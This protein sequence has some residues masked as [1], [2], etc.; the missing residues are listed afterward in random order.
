MKV[1]YQRI[2]KDGVIVIKAQEFRSQE[3]NKEEALMRLKEIIKSVTIVPKK[4]IHKKPSKISQIKRL[5]QKPR[6]TYCY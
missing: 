6:I 3:K 4:R 2:T 1:L 5:D